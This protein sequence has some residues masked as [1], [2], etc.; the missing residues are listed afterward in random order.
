MASNQHN[1][2]AEYAPKEGASDANIFV[3]SLF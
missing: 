2:E 3:I 1:Y